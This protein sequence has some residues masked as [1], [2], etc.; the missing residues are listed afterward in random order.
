MSP[1]RDILSGNSTYERALVHL[2]KMP[3]IWLDYS[4]LLRGMK[5]AKQLRHVFDRALRALPITQHEKIWPEFIEWATK[6][7]ELEGT[8]IVAYQR[9]A[10]SF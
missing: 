4:N 5:R 9:K 2:H 10:V 7:V 6:E 1:T 8:A 3:R